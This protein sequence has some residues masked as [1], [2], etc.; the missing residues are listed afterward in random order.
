MCFK[1]VTTVAGFRHSIQVLFIIIFGFKLVSL[2]TIQ[3]WYNSLEQTPLFWYYDKFLIKGFCYF[4]CFE[5]SGLWSFLTILILVSVHRI[6]LFVSYS[7][8]QFKSPGLLCSSWVHYTFKIYL[9]FWMEPCLPCL[10]PMGSSWSCFLV[11][12]RTTAQPC[13]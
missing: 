4:S 9:F 3:F 7:C 10:C 1:K 12:S 2:S 8:S 13:L 11:V 5:K 6:F